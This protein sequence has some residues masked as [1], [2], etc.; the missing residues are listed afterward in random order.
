MSGELA[1]RRGFCGGFAN[2][3]LSGEN[4]GR[5]TYA[6]D[7][8]DGAAGVPGRTLAGEAGC[9]MSLSIAVLVVGVGLRGGG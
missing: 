9:G 7:L 2:P 6:A 1:G 3:G 5:G 4:A 8:V